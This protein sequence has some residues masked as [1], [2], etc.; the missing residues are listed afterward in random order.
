MQQTKLSSGLETAANIVIGF[1]LNYL[2]NL[3][4]FPLF[5][6]NISLRNNFL[7][8]LI[9]TVISVIRSYGLRRYFNTHLQDASKSIATWWLKTLPSK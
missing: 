4:I 9:Y 6:L 2:L 5:S 3:L 8:G 7:M 1:S